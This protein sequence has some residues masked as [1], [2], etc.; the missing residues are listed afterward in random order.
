[1]GSLSVPH[2][3]HLFQPLAPLSCASGETMV[4]PPVGGVC[5]AG[6][7]GAA[8]LDATGV[9][10]V[11]PLEAPVGGGGGGGGGVEGCT[12]LVEPLL[13]GGGGG[14]GV[15]VAPV[16]EGRAAPG[17]GCWPPLCPRLVIM[18]QSMR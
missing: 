6:P 7:P 15:C 10:R 13:G 9:T 16:G 14:G 5:A 4:S 11:S 2:L 17:W 1:M 8:P 18:G 12:V 3:G